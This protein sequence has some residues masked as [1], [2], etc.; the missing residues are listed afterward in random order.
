MWDR[1]ARV[2]DVLEVG[3][4]TLSDNDTWAPILILFACLF[5]FNLFQ[6]S[7]HSVILSFLS[8]FHIFYCLLNIFGTNFRISQIS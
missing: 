8:I 6:T 2:K 1:Q 7:I 3:K 5:G 4:A